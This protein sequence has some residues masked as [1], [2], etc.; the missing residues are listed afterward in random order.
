MD[1]A[2]LVKAGVEGM[3]GGIIAPFADLLDK[4]VGPAT[5]EFGLALRDQVKFVRF[6]RSVRLLART[7]EMFESM[8]RQPEPIALK[9][10]LPILENGS[11]EEDDDLQDRW[12]ALLVN[13]SLGNQRLLPGASEILK[14]LSPFEVLLL[15]MCCD[16]VHPRGPFLEL[17]KKPMNN[18]A[19]QWFAVLAKEHNF[20]KA[21]MAHQ[22]EVDV[23]IDNLTRLGL[24]IRRP[25]KTD[26]N[27][28]YMTSLGYEFVGLCR[29]HS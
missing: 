12:A 21:G 15:Q 3:V 25:S 11:V 23:M 8:R 13:S 20:K 18:T 4:L 6:K 24:L 29:I 10:L 22:H 9:V 28:I 17:E 1:D 5:E 27:A 2:E 19:H 26:P 14:Q 16:S 7:K